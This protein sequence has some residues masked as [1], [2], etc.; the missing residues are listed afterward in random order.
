MEIHIKTT[1]R[2]HLNHVQMIKYITPVK[3]NAVKKM[4]KGIHCFCKCTLV[5]PPWKSIFSLQEIESVYLQ[6]HLYHSWICIQT[7]LPEGHFLKY[8]HSDFIH[9]S[10]KL[11]YL[12]ELLLIDDPCGRAHLTGSSA[13]TGPVVMGA[14]RHQTKQAS[15]QHS[16]MV[17]TF[18]FLPWVSAQLLW[19]IGYG[20]NLFLQNLLLVMMSYHSSRNST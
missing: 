5:Q 12:W 7:I 9:N 13:T 19:L 4:S 14:R 20:M 2:F 3:T 18:M 16:S 6:T 11:L 1:V 10:Q 17:S 15:K 8:V